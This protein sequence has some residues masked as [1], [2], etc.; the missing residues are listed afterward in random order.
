VLFIRK[1]NDCVKTE[2][3]IL[4]LFN[5]H[6]RLYDGREW[7]EGDP[8]LMIDDI[9]TVIK[10]EGKYVKVTPAVVKNNEKTQIKWNQPGHRD[11]GKLFTATLMD[12][13]KKKGTCSINYSG[14][15]RIDT[16]QSLSN[17]EVVDK[18]PAIIKKRGRVPKILVENKKTYQI[19]WTQKDHKDF[20]KSYTVSIKDLDEEKGTCSL[21][22]KGV[23]KLHIKQ[24]LSNFEVVDCNEIKRRT[25]D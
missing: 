22:Y 11:N 21:K 23:K 1:C 17:F 12:V 18:L 9:N 5:K 7:F 6:Y 15:K 2:T 13:D 16:K 10:N 14:V 24:S 3:T 25:V 20:G 4:K 19:K 8:E